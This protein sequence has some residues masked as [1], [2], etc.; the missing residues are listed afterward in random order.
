MAGS[1]WRE[2]HLVESGGERLHGSRSPLFEVVEVTGCRGG[3]GTPVALKA[4]FEGG[5]VRF[6]PLTF[7]WFYGIIY[8]S[9]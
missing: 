2:N 1:H 7:L 5:N 6:S 9:G 3:N 4:I 8:I